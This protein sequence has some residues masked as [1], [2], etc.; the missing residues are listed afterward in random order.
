MA[1]LRLGDSVRAT[2]ADVINNISNLTVGTSLTSFSETEVIYSGNGRVYTLTGTGFQG[3]TVDGES[4][5]SG[6]TLDSIGLH[7]DAQE[8]MTV[9]SLDLDLVT[10]MTAIRED[11]DGVDET[12]VE[13]IFLGLD[14]L[15]IGSETR[16][17]LTSGGVSDDGTDLTMAGN[18]VIYLDDGN[19]T[20]DSGGGD[21]EMYGGGGADTIYGGSQDDTLYGGS[22]ADII[23]GG[24]GSDR[25][26][27]NGGGDILTGGAGSDRLYGG[28]G[29]DVFAFHEGDDTG[30]I[31]DFQDGIDMIA[32]V[33]S[34][35]IVIYQSGTSTV[36]EYG[37]DSI[38]L[39][40]F[41]ADLITSDDFV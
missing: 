30:S 32:L 37:D 33:T 27:G 1:E 29:S 6:G 38:T 26:F 10:V 3:V 9:S 13:N 20:F 2:W 31:R 41:D 7:V 4:V 34:E 18:D 35:E 36:I 22:Q 19:D 21:D 15:F 8:I 40:N 12:A 5:I 28:S 14:W 24:G 16:D 39:R 17:V 25:M 23:S 11:T